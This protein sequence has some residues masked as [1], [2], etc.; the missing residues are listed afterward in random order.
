MLVMDFCQDWSLVFLIQHFHLEFFF[1]AFK[2]TLQKYAE[3]TKL[4][5]SRSTVQTET[6]H[7]KKIM[8]LKDRN[9]TENNN[10]EQSNAL[11]D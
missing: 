10:K 11:R 9:K 5:G 7:K 8:N 3:N 4:G 6:T 1:F 2:G